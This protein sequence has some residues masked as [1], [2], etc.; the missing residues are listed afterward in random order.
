MVLKPR[1]FLLYS[2]ELG[3]DLSLSWLWVKLNRKELGSKSSTVKK[4]VKHEAFYKVE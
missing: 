1:D 3:L 4:D 2:M